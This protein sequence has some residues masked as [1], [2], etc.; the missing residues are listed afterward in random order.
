MKFIKNSTTQ[1]SQ[2]TE[3]Y[4]YPKKLGF[5]KICK[6]HDKILV[7]HSGNE[8]MENVIAK[9]GFWNDQNVNRKINV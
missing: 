3:F 8:Y 9:T 4:D 1:V 6:K 5:R 2:L 7:R